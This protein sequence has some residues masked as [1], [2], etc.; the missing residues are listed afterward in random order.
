MFE[1]LQVQKISNLNFD[2]ND[3][4]QLFLKNIF[5]FY[6]NNL[7]ESDTTTSKRT[8]NDYFWRHNILMNIIILIKS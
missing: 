5:M 1:A 7:S 8:M 4:F 2:A 6:F 3:C